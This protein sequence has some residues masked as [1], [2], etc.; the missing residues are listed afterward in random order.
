MPVP[1]SRQE[2]A[3]PRIAQGRRSHTRFPLPCT[4]RRPSGQDRDIIKVFERVLTA[5]VLGV[6]GVEH[7]SYPTSRT[8]EQQGHRPL[9]SVGTL[10]QAVRAIS[11]APRESQALPIAGP[12]SLLSDDEDLDGAVLARADRRRP[13]PGPRPAQ[14]PPL[15]EAAVV[16]PPPEGCEVSALEVRQE[17]RRF[18]AAV[19][20]P[21]KM[22]VVQPRRKLAHEIAVPEEPNDILCWRTSCGWA[23]GWSSFYRTAKGSLGPGLRMCRRCFPDRTAD[24]SSSSSSS[25]SSASNSS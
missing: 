18:M 24:S 13:G 17:L 3:P 1:R 25:S 10:P 19:Q 8:L 5:A 22:L 11:D 23:Y 4:W 2:L 14:P 6:H 7:T 16:A 15:R 20:T 21:T 9:S 12:V